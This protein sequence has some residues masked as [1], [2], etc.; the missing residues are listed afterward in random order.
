MAVV[1]R[2]PGIHA[3]AL[4]FVVGRASAP[5]A[6]ATLA[7][8]VQEAAGH[9]LLLRPLHHLLRQAQRRSVSTVAHGTTRAN[10]APIVLVRGLETRAISGTQV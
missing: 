9:Q 6:F 4:R 1:A 8:P 3:Q 10:I 5:A 2:T 7:H